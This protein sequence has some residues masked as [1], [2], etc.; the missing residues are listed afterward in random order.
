MI[1]SSISGMQDFNVLILFWLDD[2]ISGYRLPTNRRCHSI[3]L[4]GGISSSQ[5]KLIGS[6]NNLS[7][8]TKQRLVHKKKKNKKTKKILILKSLQF[9]D[10]G[11]WDSRL[12]VTPADQAFAQSSVI[13]R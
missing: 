12:E 9:V 7:V 6:F 13:D 4:L 11:V 10:L 5:D 3:A 8:N 2:Q 1:T